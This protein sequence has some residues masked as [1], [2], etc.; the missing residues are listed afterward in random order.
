[1]NQQ[2]LEIDPREYSDLQARIGMTKLAV[3][4]NLCLASNSFAIVH[5]LRNAL[6]PQFWYD[7]LAAWVYGDQHAI[8]SEDSASSRNLLHV[9]C[10]FEVSEGSWFSTEVFFVWGQRH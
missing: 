2:C 7:L 10:Y 4:H 3:V 6:Q 5:M 9:N 1:M 8:L